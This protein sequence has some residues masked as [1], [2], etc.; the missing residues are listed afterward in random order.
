MRRW[1]SAS[2]LI[3]QPKRGREFDLTNPDFVS[4][5]FDMHHRME[6]E[7]VDFCGSTG[8][9]AAVTRQPG[10][11]P[12]WVLNHLHYLDSGATRLLPNAM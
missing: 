4:A 12:L 2:A 8:S 9:R 11:D 6:A 7:G 10:L 1:S 5:Y 3:P